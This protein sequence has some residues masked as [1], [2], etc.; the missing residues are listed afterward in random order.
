MAERTPPTPLRTLAT[1]WGCL[2]LSLLWVG[3]QTSEGSLEVDVGQAPL[4]AAYRVDLYADQGGLDL[5]EGRSVVASQGQRVTFDEVPAGRWSVLIQAQNGDQTTIAYSQGK[6]EV[7][8]DQTTLFQA[9]RYLPGLPGSA[10]PESDTELSAFGPNEEGLL[11]AL[12][13]P[14]LD[15]LPPATVDLRAS[16]GTG[17]VEETPSPERRARAE[18]E[19]A[20]GC[21]T[22]RL[23]TQVPSEVLQQSDPTPTRPRWGSVAPGEVVSFFVATTFRETSCTRLLSDEQTQHCLI[24]SEVIDGEPVL[25]P[26]RALEVANAFDRDNP[27]QDGDLGIYQETRARFGSEW[28]TNPTGGRDEDSRVVLVFLS[29]NSIGGSGLFGFFRPQDELSQEQIS[30]SNVGEILYINADRS[31][32]DLYDALATI[33]HELVHLVLWNEKQGQDGTFPEG[34]APENFTLDEGFAVLNEDLSGFSFEG[35]QGGN[36]FLLS[37]VSKVLEEG[38]NRPFFLFR[39]GLGDYGAGYLLCRYL[40]DRFG[41]ATVLEVTSSPATGRENIA[42][43]VALPFPALFAEFAQA[44]ALNPESGWPDPLG[45]QGLDLVGSYLDRSG[46]VFELNGLQGVGQLSLP[47]MFSAQAVLEPWGTV[48]YRADGGDGGSLSWVATGAESLLTRIVKRGALAPA[49]TVD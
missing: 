13:A 31:N 15:G 23:A 46:R 21:A 7:Q 4:A 47:G 12:Y 8:A 10:A 29:S 2:L 38:L 18:S 11:T 45:Y 48:F 36:F 44:V 20:I 17:P 14:G 35:E 40:H 43:V 49:N 33:S 6:A 27:F 5:I 9:G 41:A 37:A 26:D 22:S 24:F 34:A 30:N 3:C 25:D 1:R 32:N 28:N 42:A 16:Q 19:A 39:G